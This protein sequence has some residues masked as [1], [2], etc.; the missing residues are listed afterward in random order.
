MDE[1]LNIQI[2]NST[3]KLEYVF[4]NSVGQIVLEGEMEESIRL[5]F[6]NLSKGVYLLKIIRGDGTFIV[7]KVIKK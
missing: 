6:P 1:E 7:Q 4:L 5:F 2:H 3:D